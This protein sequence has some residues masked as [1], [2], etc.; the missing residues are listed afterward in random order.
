MYDVT[1]RVTVL[2]Y[3]YV[4]NTLQLAFTMAQVQIHV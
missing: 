4:F 3:R 2:H 1:S